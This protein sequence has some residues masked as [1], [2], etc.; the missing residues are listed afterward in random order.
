MIIP[1][2][3]F[4][5][6][7]ADFF[8]VYPLTRSLPELQD[9]SVRFTLFHIVWFTGESSSQYV[10]DFEQHPIA[11]DRLYCLGPWQV[12]RVSGEP[13]EGIRIIFSGDIY[14]DVVNDDVRWLFNPLVNDGVRLKADI[15][16]PLRML[17]RLMV[18][19]SSG[20]G[21]TDMLKAYLKAFLL[22]LVRSGSGER[23]SFGVD[24]ARLMIL[25][26][27]V[28]T[29]YRKERKVSFYASRIGLS[30]KRLNEILKMATG[31]TLTALLHYRL[32]I[33]A[34][35]QISYG[36]RNFKEIAFDLGFSEQAYF[37]RFF[38]KK[39]GQTPEAFRQQMFKLSK[40]SG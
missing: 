21:E 29:Y 17:L 2:T 25:F 28:D 13:A 35:R 31:L 37:S 24:A 26:S 38:K 15:A 22:H 18:R 23:I 5:P 39:T 3:P 30:P 16:E 34:R 33:E 9:F 11:A 6:A 19:E 14:G 32:I 36:K 4:N 20:A 1:D 12:H 27:L 7:S 8:G 10:I 40:Q